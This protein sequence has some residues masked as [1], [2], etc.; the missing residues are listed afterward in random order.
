MAFGLQRHRRYALAA[1]ALERRVAVAVHFGHMSDMAVAV[2]RD[3]LVL[4]PVA[5]S[6][7]GPAVSR[8]LFVAGP[9]LLLAVAHTRLLSLARAR[10][11][12]LS[13]DGGSAF[14]AVWR[15]LTG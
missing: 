4:R 11:H 9:R 14:Y 8:N 10:S 13:S 12:A 15:P 6:M 5:G 2:E 3:L 7:A 1:G